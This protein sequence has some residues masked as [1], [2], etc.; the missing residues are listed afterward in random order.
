MLRLRNFFLISLFSKA[1][2]YAKLW[3]THSHITSE[4]NRVPWILLLKKVLGVQSS[5][6]IGRYLFFKKLTNIIMFM[7][8]LQQPSHQIS[9]WICPSFIVYLSQ[10]CSTCSLVQQCI[11]LYYIQYVCYNTNIRTRDIYN[12]DPSLKNNPLNNVRTP[13]TTTLCCRV[14]QQQYARI[15]NTA[16]FSICSMFSGL[17]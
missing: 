16:H 8:L 1:D 13:P 17:L 9:V 11:I 5:T 4:Q 6:Y 7:L 15:L 10:E 2:Q 3:A 14:I 12:G